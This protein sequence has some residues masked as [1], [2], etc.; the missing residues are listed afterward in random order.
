MRRG[1]RNKWTYDSSPDET[2]ST[3]GCDETAVLTIPTLGNVKH[4][5][6]A[7]KNRRNV[8]RV[9]SFTVAQMERLESYGFSLDFMV[10]P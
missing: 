9:C 6:E 8:E 3:S 1:Q 10:K 7:H 5:C 2:C 4:F